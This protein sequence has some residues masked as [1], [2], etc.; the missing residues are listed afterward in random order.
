LLYVIFLCFNLFSQNARVEQMPGLLYLPE[1]DVICMKWFISTTETSDVL[2]IFGYRSLF[3]YRNRIKLI[4][5]YDD[6][7]DG[8]LL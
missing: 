4:S 3:L 1:T 7:L 6:N 2:H 8:S 5:I